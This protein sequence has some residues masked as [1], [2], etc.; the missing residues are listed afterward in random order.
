MRGSV[1]WLTIA[2]GMVLGWALDASPEM[3][4]WTDEQG[5][6]HITNQWA[7]VPEAARARVSVRQ[8]AAV[9]REGTPARE[10]TTP[11]AE[12]PIVNLPPLQMAP[13]LT[14]GPAALPPSPSLLPHADVSSWL[15]P[16]SRSLIHH[17]K[18]LSPP[19]PD[20]VRLDPFHSDFVWVGPNRVPKDI[21]TYPRMS[22]D[23]QARFRDR[24]RTLEKH[25]S[26]PHKRFP[27]RM[28]RP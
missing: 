16:R 27:I 18:K 3:Y 14:Q 20:N 22:L 21:F 5:V 2:L 9:P 23:T 17:R 28:S 6:V 4:L 8:S 26:A 11:S 13:D 25:R 15:I 24:M 19:F 12:T 1:L 10:L 7:H